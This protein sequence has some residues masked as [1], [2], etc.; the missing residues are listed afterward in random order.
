M[1]A[2]GVLIGGLGLLVTG[3]MLG[4]AE[5][6]D[7]DVA[8]PTPVDRA[9][10]SVAHVTLVD[11]D[12]S[13]MVTGLVLDEAG[14]VL[15]PADVLGGV[16]EVWARCAGGVA[17]KVSLVGTD[18]ATNLAVLQFPEPMGTAASVA[19]SPPHV[20]VEVVAMYA[21]GGKDLMKRTGTV[22]S[23][24][25]AVAPSDTTATSIFASVTTRPEVT[26]LRAEVNDRPV[27]GRV[28]PADDLV[29]G[30]LFDGG[31]RFVGLATAVPP[32]PSNEEGR[33]SMVDV[34][35]AQAAMDSATRIIDAS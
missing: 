26:M 10:N 33:T 35:P 25:D 1:V 34:M 15:I 3:L 14:H 31:G 16:E 13:T 21:K 24:G 8:A 32:A 6:T 29:G 19:D 22:A 17:E 18:E 20:G 5:P 30:L 2:A 4:S 27:D 28:T 9:S 11:E 23:A 12:G 7:T